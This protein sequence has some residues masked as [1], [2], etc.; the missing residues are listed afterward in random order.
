METDHHILARIKAKQ[1]QLS[2][3]TDSAAPMLNMGH[4]I[5]LTRLQVDTTMIYT[6]AHVTEIV[7]FF[8]E[9]RRNFM[10]ILPLTCI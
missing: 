5:G 4:G 8:I 6:P 2:E 10:N 9:W 1:K 3:Y 7:I